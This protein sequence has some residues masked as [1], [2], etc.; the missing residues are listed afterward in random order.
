MNLLEK[1]KKHLFSVIFFFFSILNTC[2]VSKNSF[3]SSAFSFPHSQ[4][5][6]LENVPQLDDQSQYQR[7]R[8]LYFQRLILT[9]INS[10]QIYIQWTQSLIWSGYM[11]TPTAN[12]VQVGGTTKSTDAQLKWDQDKKDTTKCVAMSNTG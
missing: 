6:R 12:F 8:G 2:S 10:Y 7:E 5:I 9:Q 4:L 1:E 3:F 11:F